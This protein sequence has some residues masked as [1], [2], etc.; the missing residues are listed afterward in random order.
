M[1]VAQ[2]FEAG[3]LFPL[4]TWPAV[5]GGMVTPAAGRDWRVLVIYRGAHCPL[6][7]K[8]LH[9]L[10]R[11]AP[12]FEELGIRLWALSVDPLDRAAEQAKQEKWGV[13]ILADLQEEQMR[14]LGLYISSPRSPEESD[15]NFA[16]PA[17]FVIN[18]G[19]KVQIVDVSNAPFARPDPKT[20]LAGVRFVIENDYP[21]RGTS[22]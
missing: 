16:E 21:I 15:R 6:C 10:S 22:S 12:Q 7:T 13:P 11:L 2:K 17:V 14:D 4:F 9:G 1:S 3:G 20:L 19:S 18:P 5:D 8:Y